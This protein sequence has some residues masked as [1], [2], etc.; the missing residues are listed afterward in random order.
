MAT[1]YA[2]CPKCQKSTNK[3]VDDK[4]LEEYYYKFDC[5]YCKN[6]WTPMNPTIIKT[7]DSTNILDVVCEKDYYA[8]TKIRDEVKH[9]TE[10]LKQRPALNN[11]V[12]EIIINHVRL[13]NRSLK[14]L[15]KQYE[16]K[17]GTVTVT[18]S[19]SEIMDMTRSTHLHTLNKRVK[20]TAIDCKDMDNIL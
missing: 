14:D 12:K 20:Q 13:I 6:Q 4:K 10:Y 1:I 9:L 15:I 5:R 11:Q 17:H 18:L 2:T 8:I 7:F 19:R 3:P 16:I